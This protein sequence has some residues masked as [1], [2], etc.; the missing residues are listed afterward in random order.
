MSLLRPGV[1]KQP[2]PKTEPI[3]RNYS[4][5]ETNVSVLRKIM[6]THHMMLTL[7]VQYQLITAYS[8]AE[9]SV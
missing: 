5:W 3:Y 9:Y 4:T 8:F 2:K 1:I 7:Y 6:P